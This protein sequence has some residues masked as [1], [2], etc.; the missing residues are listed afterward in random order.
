MVLVTGVV[1]LLRGVYVEVR[2]REVGLTG[3]SVG[4]VWLCMHV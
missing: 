2:S 4:V 1:L 3:P